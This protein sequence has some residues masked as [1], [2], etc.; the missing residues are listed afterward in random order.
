MEKNLPTGL[1]EKPH[2][3]VDIISH[4]ADFP[5]SAAAGQ[6]HYTSG[7]VYVYDGGHWI[8]TTT[9]SPSTTSITTGIST[10]YTPSTTTT[11][12]TKTPAIAVWAKSLLPNDNDMLY[13]RRKD[14]K[15][16]YLKANDFGGSSSWVEIEGSSTLAVGKA[17]GKV[18]PEAEVSVTIIEDELPDF[19]YGWYQDPEA[20]LFQYNS[21]GW[22]GVT[23]SV[24]KKLNK[25]TEDGK[26][27][28]LG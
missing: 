13:I 6:L 28:Y 10:T 25:M 15:L 9:M 8:S 3:G 4:G 12:V 2:R 5:I 23:D 19:E 18:A 22:V 20:H 17:A 16:Y 21:E 1:T 7:D 24:S 27:E 11:T 26:M 14:G